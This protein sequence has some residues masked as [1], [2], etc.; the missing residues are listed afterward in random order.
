M[1]ETGLHPSAQRGSLVREAMGFGAALRGYCRVILALLRREEESRRAAPMESILELLEPVILVATVSLF[2]W[3]LGRRNTSPL[4]G[5]PILFYGT[6]F[7]ALYFFIYLSGRMR[8]AVSAPRRRFPIEQRLDHIFVH[9]VIRIFDYAILGFLVFGTIYVLF[10]PDALPQ[11]FVSIAE[12]VI[13]IVMLG[14]G[15]GV[16]NLIM[17]R[18]F[19]IW[20]YFFPA[21]NRCLIFFSGVFYVVDFMPP[22]V[23][24]V[25]SFNPL[26]HA[27]TLF[28]LGFY[29]QYPALFLDRA[30][31][32]SCALLF[33]CFGLVLERVTRR[34]ESP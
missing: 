11:S 13:A 27:I 1:K 12:A 14:F 18:L 19:K 26:L 5:H 6:G 28:R 22:H 2:W 20:R 16:L 21:F 32:G 34:H 10:T 30:Y 29:P 33:V 3:F 24:H 31:L 17:G 4:G 8:G 23:R 25:L 15:W 9:I 7:F